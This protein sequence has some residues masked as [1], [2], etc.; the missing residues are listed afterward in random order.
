MV[1]ELLSKHSGSEDR[2]ISQEG[3]YDCLGALVD[4]IEDT[5]KFGSIQKLL[6]SLADAIAN[7]TKGSSETG[8]KESTI[9]LPP[10][11]S[12]WCPDSSSSLSSE[13]AG[14]DPYYGSLDSSKLKDYMTAY[15]A[16]YQAYR[17]ALAYQQ[18]QKPSPIYPRPPT[19]SSAFINPKERNSS[20]VPVNSGSH[21]P[22][23]IFPP[24]AARPVE[25]PLSYGRYGHDDLLK[26]HSRPKRDGS[27]AI[28]NDIDASKK[29]KMQSE[30]SNEDS[31]SAEEDEA[32]DEEQD[33]DRDSNE[34]Q[35]Q[36]AQRRAHK[37]AERKR[38]REMKKMFDQL[39]SLLPGLAGFERQKLSKWDILSNAVDAIDDLVQK[40]TVLMSKKQHLVSLLQSLNVQDQGRTDPSASVEISTL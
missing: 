19:I 33:L 32:E 38:R 16:Y 13:N 35:L 30:P 40:R 10:L 27:E 31:D 36:Q 17:Y 4:A 1:E 8:P 11:S 34:S 20:D 23:A 6:P 9:K 39:K 29:Q 2:S 24:V 28:S 3:D 37:F 5:D 25:E 21:A 22:R 12:M 18:T 7:P 15:A 14:L 26:A